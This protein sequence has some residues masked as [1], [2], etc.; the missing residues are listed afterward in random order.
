MPV[1]LAFM[2]VLAQPH[3]ILQVAAAIVILGGNALWTSK[4][5]VKMRGSLK[6]AVVT[7]KIARKN[8]GLLSA[9]LK[10]LGMTLKWL[11]TTA[12][13]IFILVSLLIELVYWF[14]RTSD[15]AKELKKAQEEAAESTEELNFE[16]VEQLNFISEN[17]QA[18]MEYRDA[19]E[20]TTESLEHKVRLLA[21]DSKF[22]KEALKLTKGRKGGIC[23]K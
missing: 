13:G 22:E 21:T 7:M 4:A 6:A 16:F 1:V 12:G 17:T 23:P 9:A 10:G 3:R 18:L 14:S 11:T 5:F 20:E 2:K 19:I 15:E 8:T